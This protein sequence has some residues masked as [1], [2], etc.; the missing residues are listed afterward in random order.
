M[1]DERLNEDVRGFGKAIPEFPGYTG[2]AKVCPTIKSR[3]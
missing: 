3:P 1:H 2:D